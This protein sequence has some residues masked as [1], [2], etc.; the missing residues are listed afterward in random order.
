MDDEI[1]YQVLV[2]DRDAD[3]RRRVRQALEARLGG[4][5]QVTEAPEIDVARAL[6]QGGRFDL[7]LVDR[8]V[9]TSDGRDA[10]EVALGEAPTTSVLVHTEFLRQD[11]LEALGDAAAAALRAPAAA[12]V[13]QREVR[14]RPQFAALYP[15]VRPGQWGPAG[16]IAQRVLVRILR[17][18]PPGSLPR[19]RVLQDVHFE[20][21]GGGARAAGRTGVRSRVSD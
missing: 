20:F 19:G 18:S 15:D 14:L 21:R 4:R 8:A 16:I 9:R 12:A 13:P 11:E 5:V 2:I 3:H 7:V 6:L 1:A 10:L 17:Y